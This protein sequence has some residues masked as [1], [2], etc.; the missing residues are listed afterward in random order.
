MKRGLLLLLVAVASFSAAASVFFLGKVHEENQVVDGFARASTR[1]IPPSDTEAVALA[2][3]RQVYLR[4]NR[5][6]PASELPL[7][8]RVESTSFF[9]VTSAVSLRHNAYGVTGQAHEGPCGT[10]TRVTLVGLERLGI[11]A[12]KLNLHDESTSPDGWHA[13]LEFRDG[14]R[15]LVLSPSDGAFV[16]R[17]HE[18]RI[19][20]LGEIQADSTVFGEI[21]AR[22][23]GYPYRFTRATHI[24]WEKVPSAIRGLC[25]L[26]LGPE[27]Y[28]N[29]YT[30]KL[31]DRPRRLFL[32]AALSC[33]GSFTLGALLVGA[34]RV[35]GA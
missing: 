17:T 28:R 27:G 8:E 11:S 23:P 4:T 19:A 1:G 31:Y 33:L 3:A 9:N 18:G 14:G 21:F 15:W 2:L 13:M 34:G 12:R 7:Y 20:T 16:W 29:A 24:R 10:M 5:T 6:I 32:L 22:F 30:P 35:A 26:V 25:R